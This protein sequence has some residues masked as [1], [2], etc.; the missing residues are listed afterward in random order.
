MILPG[1]QSPNAGYV[2]TLTLRLKTSSFPSGYNV[3]ECSVCTEAKPRHLGRC[4]SLA[5]SPVYTSGGLGI[6]SPYT[7]G[8]CKGTKTA[9]GVLRREGFRMLYILLVCC[10]CLAFSAV[11]GLKEESL[12]QFISILLKLGP[13]WKFRCGFFWSQEVGGVI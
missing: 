5:R 7:R 2:P 8:G 9:S 12:L 10:C 3:S 6:L 4:H 13:H 11:D 1:C